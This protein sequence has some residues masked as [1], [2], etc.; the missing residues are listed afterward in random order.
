MLYLVFFI[1]LPLTAQTPVTGSAWFAQGLEQHSNCAY[2]DAIHSFQS[3][4]DLRF[5]LPGASMRIARA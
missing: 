1:L 5:N 2:D 3:A 4:L